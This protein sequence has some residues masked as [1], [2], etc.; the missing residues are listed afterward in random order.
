MAKNEAYGN[1]TETPEALLPVLCRIEQVL[2]VVPIKRSTIWL[3]ARQ[4]RF[5]Q[6]FKH[7]SITLWK[8]AEVLAWLDQVGKAD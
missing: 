6:P 3:W 7:G 4:G 8:R 1:Q 5:P 2:K